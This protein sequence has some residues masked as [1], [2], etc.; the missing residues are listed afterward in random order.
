MTSWPPTQPKHNQ[1][2]R[3]SREPSARH[4]WRAKVRTLLNEFTIERRDAL[5][6]ERGQAVFRVVVV[7]CLIGYF[8]YSFYPFALTPRP[9]SWLIYLV[10]YLLLSL[11]VA[12]L[13]YRYPRASVL[14]RTI[15]NVADIFTI[16]YL[17]I[18]TGAPGIPL[19][20]LY[21][22]ATLGSG[23]RFGLGA[24]FASA[25][26]S[27]LGF[28]AVVA[29]S[30][31]WRELVMVSVAVAIALVVL[32]AHAA[33]LIH[34]RD[35]ATQRAE[36]ANAAKSRFLARMS[37]ELRTP[38]NGIMGT[39]ELLAANKRLLRE[40][41]SLL[42]VIRESVNV[43]L[44]Q[45]DNV[46]DFSKIEAGKLIIEELPFDLHGLLNR[47]VH[48]IRGIALEKNL[49]LMLRIDPAIPHQLVGDPHHLNEV[50]LNLLSNATKFT[51]H[52]FV[53]LEAH[54]VELDEASA[55]V[56]FEVHDTGVGIE[57]S[58][59]ERIF[60]AF[61]QEDTA[62][63]RRYGG[64][65]LGTTIS[66]Q[67][68]ELMGGRLHVTSTKGVGSTFFATIR[69]ARAVPVPT[70]STPLAAMRVLLVTE[71][72]S[73]RNDLARLAQE[74]GAMLTA[75]PSVAEA[76]GVLGR[77]IRLNNSFHAVL[78]DGTAAFTG[79]GVHRADDF[80]EKA[81]LSFTPS[82]LVCAE[83]P[84]VG[85]VRRWGYAWALPYDMSRAT[86]FSALRTSSLYENETEQ[87]VIQVEPWAWRQSGRQRTRLLIADD[88]RT[89]LMIL[90][91]VLE[92]ANYEVDAAEDGE[93]ALTM[94]LDGRYKAAILDMHMPGL[95]GVEVVRQY[96]LLRRSARVPIVMLT[97]NATVDAKLASAESGADAYLTKPATAAAIVGTVEKLLEETEVYDLAR[98]RADNVDDFV[99]A[100]LLNPEV[101]RELDRLYDDPSGIAGIV[102]EFEGESRRLLTRLGGAISQ[103]N[104]AAFCDALHALKGNCANVGA[105]RLVQTCHELENVGLLEFR[106][107]GRN[108]LQRLESE[109]A[110]TMI[111]LRELTTVHGHGPAQ[112]SDLP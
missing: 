11:G 10:G 41:R 89:N 53:S 22:W 14:R 77:A 9:P 38:L 61:S 20:M 31:E 49:R 84:E 65:G 93:Q 78:V 15:A 3:S 72:I 19:F 28:S 24:L 50:L 80:L 96:R 12:T 62:T 91:K 2:T 37:H 23:F 57:T 76:T 103:K 107:D 83:S 109:V 30:A 105:L 101:I 13:A 44:R 63:T 42:D 104:H 64:T 88:N 87:G 18:S 25:A 27:V 99:Q 100:P 85:Q 59:L 106:R 33:H 17:M 7:L 56:R 21:L 79:S 40:D 4:S 69:F 6:R 74:F 67:L 75:V 45:I 98:R 90:R 51:K 70:S 86:L 29:F 55:V 43:S 16:S 71:D 73:L 102:T 94:M 36:E 47:A 32:P 108:Q 8:T 110:E 58:A 35:T 1:T 82:F 34:L 5:A 26:L 39:V 81:W 48:I 54:L 68:V 95:D 52:G 60:E 112:G 66:R 97:A 92:S 46:L 111:A